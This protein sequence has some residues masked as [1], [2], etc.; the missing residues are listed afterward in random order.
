MNT[1]LQY[2][3]LASLILSVAGGLAAIGVR[4]WLFLDHGKPDVR[5]QWLLKAIQLA[6]QSRQE[7]DQLVGVGSGTT[8]E[9]AILKEIAA[10]AEQWLGTHGIHMHLDPDTVRLVLAELRGI[11]KAPAS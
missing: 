8:P 1:L 7:W 11:A 6:V 9:A 3:E 10:T 4:A 5:A 2:A